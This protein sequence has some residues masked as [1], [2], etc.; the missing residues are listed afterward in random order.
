VNRKIEEWNAAVS[1][2]RSSSNGD[3]T[4]RCRANYSKLFRIGGT[5]DLRSTA[6]AQ[7]GRTLRLQLRV[8]RPCGS[9]LMRSQPRTRPRQTMERTERLPHPSSLNRALVRTDVT[10]SQQCAGEGEEG[11][12][13]SLRLFFFF[14]VL[15]ER[16]SSQDAAKVS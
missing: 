7:W 9:E 16:I 6:D 2:S 5:S 15:R 13:S 14:F 10:Q 3:T 11:E 4:S 12:V 1:Q 8:C